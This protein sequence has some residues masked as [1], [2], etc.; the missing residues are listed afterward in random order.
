M[1]PD[2]IEAIAKRRIEK[3][4]TQ[5]VMRPQFRFFATLAL[6]LDPVPVPGICTLGTDGDNMFYDPMIV[7]S[8][9]WTNKELIGVIAHEALHAAMLHHV[10]RGA[11]DPERWNIACDRVINGHLLNQGFE[12][13]EER[14]YEQGDENFH[15]EKLYEEVQGEG[16]GT[17]QGTGNG[18]GKPGDGQPMPNYGNCGCVVD[19]TAGDNGQASA[20]KRA[21]SE[22]KWT[23]IAKQA[24]TIAAAQG[25]LPGAFQHLLE[26][27]KTPVDPWAVL[28][29]FADLCRAED[30]SW[31]RMNRRYIGEGLYL[32]TLY[33]EGVGEILIATDTSGSV[34]NKQL[35]AALGFIASVLA[36]V[37]PAKTHFLQVDASVHR[38]DVFDAYETLPQRVKITGRGGTS[39]APIWQYAEKH[40]ITPRCGVV[41]TD[42]E[43]DDRSFGKDPGYPVL[44]LNIGRAGQR[45]P[46]GE[47]VDIEVG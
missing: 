22:R 10:R 13:P 26:P 21:E 28:R 17:G 42:M 12:L 27:T 30:Y 24:A 2:E 31:S 5:L 33:S 25:H 35:S 29:Q 47:T 44:W 20:A 19:A 7:A 6:H 46:W 40:G 39:M 4:R 16:G 1:N 18:S 38:H 37:R 43:M 32:P 8:D 34:S 45:A 3:A 15:A 41:L 9:L 36:D 23:I 11:R 14:L